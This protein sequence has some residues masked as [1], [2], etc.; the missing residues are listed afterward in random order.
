MNKTV[1]QP[2]NIPVSDSASMPTSTSDALPDLKSKVDQEF[3]KIVEESNKKVLQQLDLIHHQM[4]VTF[5][6]SLVLYILG[7]LL[8]IVAIIV[9]IS[10]INGITN[11]TSRQYTGVGLVI[12]G[13]ILL[14]LML[15]RNPFRSFRHTIATLLRTNMIMLGFLY[16]INQVNSS[17]G[18]SGERAREMETI[19]G[20]VL[21]EIEAS[22]DE[23]NG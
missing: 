5:W 18:A 16:Q 8:G 1:D 7:I 13:L 23:N 17:S 3:L 21:D 10:L 14:I 15:F 2:E 22:F 11:L 20:Q 9:G 6:V 19:I 12:A 4:R